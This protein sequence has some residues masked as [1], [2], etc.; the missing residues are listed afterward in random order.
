MSNDYENLLAILG[1][2]NTG[3]TFTAFEK[4]FSYSSGIFGFPLR[5]L[6]RENYD[7]AVK[8]I[9]LSNV[10][11]IT[12][13]EKIFPKEA[14]YFFC[15]VE[16]MPNNISVECVI[17]DEIQLSADYERGHIF[18]DRILNLRGN[19]QTIFL[20]S[21]NIENILKK[22]YPKISIEKKNRFS[23][24]TFLRKQNFSKLEPRSAIIAF[25][26]NKVYEIA[27]NIRTHKGG[28][29]VVLGSLSPRTRNAQV[30]VYENNNV[31]Y[32]VATDAI[33]MGLNL[34]INHVSFSSL[35]KFDG[36]Y[37]RNLTPSELG[38]IAGRAGRYK[39]D[40]T[41]SY[42]KEAGNLD[43]LTILQIENH[44]FDN[45]QKIYWRNS[46]LDFNSI[47]SLL[48]SLKKYPIHNYLIHKK[49]ALDEVNFRNLINDS[50][51]KRFLVSKRNIELL[52]K[53][54]QIPDFEK[55]FNDNYLLLLKDIYLILI[56]NNYHIP[57]EWI[58]NKVKKL[59]NFGGGIPELSIKISQ[60]RTWTYITNNHNWLKNTY[61]WKEKTQQIENEL[62]DELHNSLTNKFI[63]Y[64]S[65]FFI[66]EKK[67]LNI[68]DIFIKNNNEIFLEKDKYGIIR[69][70]D[71]IE[72]K[73][74][75]S[76][77]LFS[78]SNIKKSARNMINEKVENFLNS[79][80]DS[81]NC[82]DISKSKLKDDTFIYW[83]DEPVGKLKKGKSIYRPT[84]D[85]LNSEYLSS[86]NKLLVSAKLQKWLDTEINESLHP[87]NKKLDENINSEIRAIA[88]NCLENF[89]NY[90]I[91][92]FKDILKTISQDSRNQLSKL[93]IRIGAKYFFIPNLLKKKPLELCAILWKTFYQNNIDYFLPLPQDGRVSF[94]SEVKMP[95]DYWQSIGYINIKNFIFRIDIFEKIFFLARQKLKQGPFLESSDLMNPIGCN[96]NQLK[97]IMIFCGYE[98]L[99]ISDEKKLY[100]HSKKK[101]ETKKIIKN[102]SIKKIDKTNNKNKTKRDPNSPFAVLEKLL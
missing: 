29:A 99:I 72:E 85:A 1:P 15:T 48:S 11:L 66:G 55:L 36:K 19:F 44:N 75:F 33:G 62:S 83:G 74:I 26:I 22:I 8:R 50:E 39:Q 63:D 47:D 43:P 12:G 67:F 10:A 76:Q 42:T 80:L 14:K 100:F 13:E 28:T 92:K 49:N 94:T 88:F 102:K 68:E 9:G 56:E 53:I 57:E 73:K 2:T 31:D 59:N 90:P 41:F 89:G 82:G 25:N 37:N 16:S 60:I 20:G 40:G 17:I 79:P 64:S 101:K 21:L 81:I 91:E 65:K 96:S 23:Q 54:C 30:E 98:Y 32:L 45:I 4:L 35:E 87:L 51:I 6:A 7:K 69:G 86:E 27:E 97:D 61:Y 46:D 5:L 38:Q 18:T 70:F 34:N 95:D 71:L 58:N 78:I 93:G 24:L 52:W 3:K 77:S 84:V